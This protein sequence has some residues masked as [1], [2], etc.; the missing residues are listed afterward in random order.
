[1]KFA[2]CRFDELP[3]KKRRIEEVRSLVHVAS[4][5]VVETLCQRDGDHQRYVDIT[6]LGNNEGSTTGLRGV[7]GKVLSRPGYDV[8]ANAAIAAATNGLVD[9]LKVIYGST[10]NS[11]S[12]GESA[13]K[14]QW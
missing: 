5:F 3:A 11:R 7:A 12:Y 8:T 13:G 6:V 10:N 4:A 1:M 9:V 2:D 14:V